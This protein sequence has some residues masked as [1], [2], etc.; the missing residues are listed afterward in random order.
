M[1]RSRP[2]TLAREATIPVALSTRMTAVVIALVVLVS[3]RTA[4]AAA[5]SR[6]DAPVAPKN[7]SPVTANPAMGT[8]SSSAPVEPEPIPAWGQ[9]HRWESRSFP[10]GAVAITVLP[11]GTL[12]A[13]DVTGALYRSAAAS[14]W[15][16]VMDGMAG[17]EELTGQELDE[18]K[19]LL[20]A[21]SSVEDLSDIQPGETTGDGTSG[22]TTSRID[23][24]DVREAVEQGLLDARRNGLGLR[25]GQAMLWA[26]Y[27]QPGLV[28]FSRPDGSWRSEDGGRRWAK[29]DLLGQIRAVIDFPGDRGALLA[30]T[31]QGLYYSGDGGHTWFRVEGTPAALHVRALA[32]DGKTIYAGTRAGLYRTDDGMHWDRVLPPAYSDVSVVDIACDR[33]WDGGLWMVTTEGILRSDDRGDHFHLSSRNPLA[34]TRRVLPLPHSPGHLLSAGGQGVWES[35]D[36]G[37]RWTA[38]ATGLAG[39]EVDDIALGPNGVPFIATPN[40]VFELTRAAPPVNEAPS[41]TLEGARMEELTTPPVAE[42]VD[43]ALSRAGIDMDPLTLRR[44]VV[45][46]LYVPR[47]LLKG[48]LETK[49]SLSADLSALSNDG[50]SER[51][52][53][54]S[55]QL[56]F[57]HCSGSSYAPDYYGAELSDSDLSDLYDLAVI[58]TEVYDVTDVTGYAAAA[59]NVAQRIARYRSALVDI[60]TSLYFSRLRLLRERPAVAGLPLIDQV[61]HELSIAEVTAR[62]DVY[63]D[64]TFSQAHQGS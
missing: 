4:R 24:A 13:A 8:E 61:R 18:E 46:S 28:I 23:P 44:G 33:S 12:L 40:G 53:T 11:D 15:R 9:R 21:E 29:L 17:L 59:S 10:D 7:D 35:I 47:V 60:V 19:L 51:N 49:H 30:G 14:V 22:D 16:S 2:P 20:E 64:G 56:C 41:T 31:E 54:I 5:P 62:L 6:A 37:V 45:R 25:A 32:T 3:A 63:T 26:S 52:W 27:G 34:G 39:P 50:S 43:R 48:K 57:G 1:G 36:G 55:A 58:G 38:L 42:V